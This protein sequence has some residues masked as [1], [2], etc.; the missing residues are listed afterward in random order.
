MMYIN[1]MLVGR[2]RS[3]IHDAFHTSAQWSN[4]RH[5]VEAMRGGN[6]G[7]ERGRSGLDH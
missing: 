6:R 4:K 5:L 7:A 1:E 3:D 2:A